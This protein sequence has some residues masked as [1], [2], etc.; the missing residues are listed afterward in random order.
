MSTVFT[1][2][3]QRPILGNNMDEHTPES[4][5]PTATDHKSKHTFVWV[6]VVLVAIVI[7]VFGLFAYSHRP[8]MGTVSAI[9]ATGITIRPNGSSSTK[10]FSITGVTKM[11][12]PYSGG[13]SA[14]DMR[15]QK[16]NAT[17]IHVGESVIVQAGSSSSEAQLVTVNPL[18]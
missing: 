4:T 3:V 10:T 18:Q 16:F 9:S 15:P 14:E 12:L 2:E 5:Q 6:V 7:I 1:K 8:D 11:G 13:N 17:D